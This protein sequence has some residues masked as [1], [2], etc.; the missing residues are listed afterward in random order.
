MTSRDVVLKAIRFEGPE[1]LPLLFRTAPD[2]SD[3][4]CASYT[5]PSGWQARASDVDEWGC[6]W[7]N[8]VGA[9]TGHIVCNPLADIESLAG[10]AFPDPRAAGRF[11]S[12]PQFVRKYPDK[13][14]AGSMGLSG[15]NLMMGLRGFVGLMVDLWLNRDFLADLTDV[16]WNFESAIIEQ[17]ADRGVHGVWFYDDWGMDRALFINPELWREVFKPLYRK[18]FKLAHDR[19]LHVFFH[20]CGYVWDII[21]DLIEIGADCLNLEQP[22]IFGKGEENGID[23]LARD[24][25][26]KVCFCTNPD[27]QTTL[28]LSSPDE[29]Y[30]EAKHIVEVFRRFNGGLIALADCGKDANIVPRR[31]LEAMAHAFVSSNP[32]V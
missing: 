14:V 11:D 26:G 13:Y 10:C 17:Y 27:L 30:A 20:S 12:V 25:G 15:F 18:E 32:S 22:C 16:I 4:V 29:V 9:G 28:S 23:L 21:R 3:I 6:K 1:R 2:R 19:G 5:M 31:N 7:S 24:F 8:L